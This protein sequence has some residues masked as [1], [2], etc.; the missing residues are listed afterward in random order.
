MF[1]ALP[2]HRPLSFGRGA[3]TSSSPTAALVAGV[4][5]PARDAD[6]LAEMIAALVYHYDPDE[7][8]G[9]AL[10]DVCIND[11]DFVVTAPPRRP[12]TSA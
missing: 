12:S 1:T 2:D 7:D 8:G 5:R 9:T 10:T 11:G 6:L 4:A 3:L